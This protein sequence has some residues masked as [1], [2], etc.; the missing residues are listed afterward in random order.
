MFAN[1]GTLVKVVPRIKSKALFFSPRNNALKFPQNASLSNYYYMT[2][3]CM[4]QITLNMF[5]LKTC[6][7]LNLRKWPFAC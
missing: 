3:E 5:Y 7:I 6:R 2:R 4:P 1:I